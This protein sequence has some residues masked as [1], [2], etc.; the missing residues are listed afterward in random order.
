[1]LSATLS[2]YRTSV[3]EPKVA[4]ILSLGGG[5]VMNPG[6]A[7]MVHENTLCIYLRA[8][9]GTLVENL[10][11][12]SEGRP[13]LQSSSSLEERVEELMSLRAGTYESTAHIIIDIDGK[14]INDIANAIC[15]GA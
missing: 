1:M 10:K 14:T 11:E 15:G 7:G 6:C 12:E 3:S 5:T 2:Q 9:I 4:M 13:M 8:S